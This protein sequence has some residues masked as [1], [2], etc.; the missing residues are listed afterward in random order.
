MI[1]HKKP[2]NKELIDV[3]KAENLVISGL[4]MVVEYA[5]GSRLFPINITIHEHG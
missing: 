1:P 2:Q 5:T 4:R 3:Q